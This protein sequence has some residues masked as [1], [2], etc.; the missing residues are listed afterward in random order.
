MELARLMAHLRDP[1]QAERAVAEAQHLLAVRDEVVRMLEEALDAGDPW[2]VQVW[3][4]RALELLGFSN[5]QRGALGQPAPPG[6]AVARRARLTQTTPAG[7][8]SAKG[9]AI[10]LAPVNAGKEGA[11]DRLTKL[12]ED[13]AERLADLVDAARELRRAAEEVERQ[14]RVAEAALEAL[15]RASRAAD[16]S[17]GAEGADGTLVS[18]FG[19]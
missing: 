12:L 1:Q 3:I 19:G 11:M 6:P 5:R 7:L 18:L 17:E 8:T 4:R 10:L 14:A 9:C 16:T 2:D 15:D 13:A